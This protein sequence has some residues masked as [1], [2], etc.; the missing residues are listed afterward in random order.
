MR[1]YAPE[2]FDEKMKHG[3]YDV[4]KALK[5]SCSLDILRSFY[6]IQQHD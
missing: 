6:D 3:A 2:K 5:F 4:V 1:T